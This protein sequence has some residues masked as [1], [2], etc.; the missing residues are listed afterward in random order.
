M[1]RQCTWLINAAT[2]RIS[3]SSGSETAALQHQLLLLTI[4]TT[5]TIANRQCYHYCYRH[6][7]N[8]I[9]NYMMT[10]GCTT[11]INNLALSSDD[12]LPVCLTL[13]N[14]RVPV[15]LALMWCEPPVLDD[16]I[17]DTSCC[18]AFTLS[19]SCQLFLESAC[20][21]RGRTVLGC[22]DLYRIAT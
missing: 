7:K 13:L 15:E 4:I 20:N 9:H 3:T 17:R 10:Y 22:F 11:Y 12:S 5:T 6:S 1:S 21:A 8:C 14:T 18:S 19:F 2:G 16:L